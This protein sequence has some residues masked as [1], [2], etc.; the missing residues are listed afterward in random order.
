MNAQSEET[1]STRMYVPWNYQ[2]ENNSVNKHTCVRIIVLLL[3][4]SF[5]F[6][7]T[8]HRYVFMELL[9]GNNLG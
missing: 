1:V 3:S 6:S 4:I 8:L 2:I 9:Y 7:V 5:Y